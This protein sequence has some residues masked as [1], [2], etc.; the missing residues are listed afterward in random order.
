MPTNRSPL[1]LFELFRAAGVARSSRPEPA[2]MSLEAL[3]PRVLLSGSLELPEGVEVRPWRDGQVVAVEDSWIATFDRTVDKQTLTAAFST[4]IGE[5]GIAI[6]GYMLRGSRFVEFVTPDPLNERAIDYVRSRVGNLINIE[7][8][9]A[10]APQRVANDPL[11]DLAWWIDNEGQPIPGQPAGVPG[12]DISLEEAW[13][14]TTGSSGVVIA[15]I[16]TGVEWYH[17]DLA[18]NIWQNAGEIPGNGIDDDGNGYVDDVRGWDFGTATFGP[19]GTGAFGGD[20]DPDDNAQGGGHGTAVAGTIGAVGNNGIGIAGVNWDVSI[21]PIKIANQQGALVGGAIVAAH[22][23]LTDLILRGVNI[24]ASNNSYG[25]FAPGFYGDEFEEFDFER[26]AIE[27]FIAA[28]ATFVASAGNDSND[29]DDAFTSYPAAYDLPGI[30]SVAATN[31]RD[32]LAS[33]SNY[34][35]TT[36]DVAAPGEAILTTAVNN[37]Y[38]FID[39]T[40]FSG[41]DRGGHRRAD[42]DGPPRPDPRTGDQRPDRLVGPH[43]GVAGPGGRRRPGER[44]PRVAVH[45]DRRSACAADHARPDRRRPPVA[46]AG[47]LQRAG[48]GP[49]GGHPQ[50]DLAGACRGRRVVLRRQR[51]DHRAD[52]RGAGRHRHGADHHPPAGS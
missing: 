7:P 46:A 36:V 4:V 37:S 48:A 27:D 16:D 28:G 30:I 14:V 26:E 11:N 40:S 21:L 49:A 32:E 31:N 6:D 42:E 13:E 20:N 25:A 47:F 41:P 22:N 35:A 2:A 43:R 9:V 23:Y 1:R 18:D 45:H 33:F 5:L 29:N 44:R 24:V 8:N 51:G 39:G 52:Q 19:G 38:T 10:Y 34:G 50:P 15:V 12:A 17:E 3:E